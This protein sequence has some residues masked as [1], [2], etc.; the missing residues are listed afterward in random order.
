M[1][2]PPGDRQGLLSALR[3]RPLLGVAWFALDAVL[4]WAYVLQGNVQAAA[5]NASDNEGRPAAK[6]EQTSRPAD[7]NG[8]AP[9]P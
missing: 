5:W 9:V 1:D 2:S 4:N 7:R 8:T 3:T 6:P